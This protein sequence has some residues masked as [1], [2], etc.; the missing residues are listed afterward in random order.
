MGK[1]L[2]LLIIEDS[3]SDALLILR[4]I[5]K[6]GYETD[7]LRVDTAEGMRAALRGRNWDLVLSDHSMP[8]FSSFE[9]LNILK[10]SGRDIPFVV[11]SG[12]IGEELAV[13]AMRMGAS[14][15]VMKDKLGRLLPI[16]ARETKEVQIREARRKAELGFRES[17]ARFRRIFASNMVGIAFV[18]ENGYL[19]DANEM[20]LQIVGYQR[21]DLER[22]PI[23]LEKITPSEFIDA[24]QM[25]IEL[26]LKQGAV[27]P[28]EKQFFR[29]NGSRVDVLV[30]SALIENVQDFAVTFVIDITEQKQIEREKQRLLER[31]RLKRLIAEVISRSFDL[32]QIL[33]R[34]A[35]ALGSFLDVDRCFVVRYEQNDGRFNFN[36]TGAYY[37]SPEIH[38]I[39]I[40]DLPQDLIRAL[41]NNIPLEEAMNFQNYSTQT[42]YIDYLSQRV[43]M[44]N[45]SDEE[46]ARLHEQVVDLV[47][48]RFGTQ[49]LLRVGIYYRGIPYGVVTLQQ[50]REERVWREDEIELLQDVATQVGIAFYQADLYQ[51]EQNARKQAEEANRKKSE[52]LA[53]M[54]HELRTPLNA[55]IGYSE[56]LESGIAGELGEKQIKYIRNVVS[57]GRHLLGIVNDLLDVSRL[58]AGKM[59]LVLEEVDLATLLDNVRAMML[60]MAIKNEVSL[61]FHLEEEL[62]R[63]QADPSRLRQILVNLVSNAIKFNRPGGRVEVMVSRSPD[64]RWMICQVKDT[65]IGIPKNKI[66]ELFSKFY[67][68]NNTSTRHHEGTGLGLALTRQLVEAHGGDITVESEEGKGAIFTFRLPC[69]QTD[70]PIQ[71]VDDVVVTE[72]T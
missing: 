9:A 47:V 7:Y 55:I 28:Y 69:V 23:S 53:M 11:I 13:E 29:K 30:A 50:C 12:T 72:L 46:K 41:A 56:M 19:T 4:E 66:R 16:I 38:E 31:E 54:S 61:E 15:Y 20:F 21:E 8:H 37:R 27:K 2:R 5:G 18:G 68:V 49:A 6:G 25:A 63:V 34:I 40:E 36:L 45:V 33:N 44:L 39:K 57:S 62:D 51:H 65:G 24:D 10:E 42:Q 35:R 58:E 71:P 17:E 26:L 67:Q 22:S 1:E 3:E 70:I 60:E 43:S 52:F 32:N 14:D 59:T 64:H 48:N